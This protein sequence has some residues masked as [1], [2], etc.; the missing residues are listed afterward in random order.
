MQTLRSN[1]PDLADPLALCPARV[2]EFEGQ[3]RHGFALFQLARTA[4]PVFWIVL[5]MSGTGFCPGH[6]PKG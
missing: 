3:G 6:C 4:G 5:A 2:H 1:P